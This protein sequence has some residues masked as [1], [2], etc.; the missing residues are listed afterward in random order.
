MI[1][2]IFIIGMAASGRQVVCAYTSAGSSFVMELGIESLITQSCLLEG[3]VVSN[4]RPAYGTHN[5]KS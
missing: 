3:N 5:Y 4:S 1:N 2:C